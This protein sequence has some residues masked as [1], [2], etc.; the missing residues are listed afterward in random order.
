M[1]T[2]VPRIL[3]EDHVVDEASGPHAHRDR[4]HRATIDQPVG[5]EGDHRVGVG[6]GDVVDRVDRGREVV[7]RHLL[8]GRG[9]TL[10][11]LEGG[12]G[13][14]QGLRDAARAGAVGVAEVAVA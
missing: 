8:E 7:A 12:P 5:A 1:T 4:E 6:D 13:L 10:A 3:A 2:N 14:R 9:A 11:G